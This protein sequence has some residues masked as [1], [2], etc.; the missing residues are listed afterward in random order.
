MARRLFALFSFEFIVLMWLLNVRYSSKIIP[1]YLTSLDSTSFT[2]FILIFT[3]G[4]K[5]FLSL[6]NI[7]SVFVEFSD[8]LFANSQ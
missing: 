6:K 7:N 1:T 3:S 4:I 2:P 8:I 5:V